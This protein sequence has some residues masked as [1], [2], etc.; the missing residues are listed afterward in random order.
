MKNQLNNLNK[1]IT[2]IR[3]EITEYIK[4]IPNSSSNIT[5]INKNCGIIKSSE[6]NNNNWSP[7]Y[8]IN[9]D[10]KSMLINILN[11]TKIENFEKSI[12]FIIEKKQIK[13][14]KLNDEFIN[15]LKKIILDE[16]HN[17]IYRRKLSK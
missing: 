9:S 5:M 13:N 8:Y 4:N 10:T 3:N 12:K 11:Y 1:N 17:N 7:N 16:E 2:K 14:I 15:N 6:L